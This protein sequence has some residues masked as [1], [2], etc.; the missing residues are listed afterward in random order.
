MGQMK[1]FSKLAYTRHDSP[2]TVDLILPRISPTRCHQLL[3]CRDKPAVQW[4]K[5][6]GRW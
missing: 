6:V 4:K 5:R 2:Y 3:F 1:K